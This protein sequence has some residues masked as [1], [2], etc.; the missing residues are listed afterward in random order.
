MALG[1]GGSEIARPD[2]FDALANLAGPAMAV[3]YERC[4]VANGFCHDLEPLTLRNLCGTYI[5]AAN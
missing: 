3:E 2:H 5:T 1:F 4:L